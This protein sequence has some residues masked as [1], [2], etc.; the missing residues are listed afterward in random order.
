MS[1]LTEKAAYLKG[2]AEGLELTPDT[3]ERKLLLA[4]LG[5][6]D[7]LSSALSVLEQRI[8]DAEDTM[9]E[10]SDDLA[11]VEEAVFDDDFDDY[12]DDDED[13][14]IS[15]NDEDFIEHYCPHCG[16]GIFFD[17]DDF[18]MEEPHPCPNCGKELFPKDKED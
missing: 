10:I 9:D 14:L 17:P 12:D 1:K 5:V 7:D 13:G 3:A 8:Q 18:N 15:L 4:M 6:I 16:D 2:L 11:D